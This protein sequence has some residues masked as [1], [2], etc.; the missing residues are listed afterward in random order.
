MNNENQV[1]GSIIFR[2]NLN[3]GNKT[4]RCVD[5]W[6]SNNNVINKLIYGS[7]KDLSFEKCIIYFDDEKYLYKSIL[8]KLSIFINFFKPRPLYLFS[9]KT[10]ISDELNK[11]TNKLDFSQVYS[12]YN[13]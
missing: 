5:V 9:H 7:I 6:G 11:K 3:N 13:F 2:E 10:E 12:D 1:N 4:Y 8:N